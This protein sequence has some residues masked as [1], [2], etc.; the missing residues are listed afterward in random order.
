MA[1]IGKSRKGFKK[2]REIEEAI[3]AKTRFGAGTIL[4]QVPSWMWPRVDVWTAGKKERRSVK[5]HRDAMV[6]FACSHCVEGFGLCRFTELRDGIVK[7][8]VCR[9]TEENDAFQARQVAKISAH[10]LRQVYE[11]RRVLGES[12][13]CSKWKISK[14][15]LN[16]ACITKW[17]RL[18]NK[19]LNIQQE[20]YVLSNTSG[21]DAAMAKFE[22]YHAEVTAICQITHRRKAATKAAAAAKWAAK[23][24][25]E[26]AEMLAVVEEGRSQMAEAVWLATG[27]HKERPWEWHDAGRYWGELTKSEFATG[28]RVSAFGWIVQIVNQL[29]ADVADFIF[30]SAVGRFMDVVKATE[31]G[32]ASRSAAFLKRGTVSKAK[33]GKVQRN[34]YFRPTMSTSAIVAGLSTLAA[35]A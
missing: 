27:G 19:P 23:S 4:R 1:N 24:A 34:N 11:D 32:R 12:V 2:N 31:Y 26:K 8:C 17:K 33:R 15:T 14:E 28:C 3:A 10:N 7:S 9:Q 6:V 18:S 25:E 13:T 5:K 22:L 29:D 30:G 35:A 16:A 20:I 21:V